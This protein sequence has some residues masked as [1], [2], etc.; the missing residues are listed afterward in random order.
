M[1][2]IVEIGGKQFRVAKDQNLKV[3]KINADNGSSI[4]FDRVLFFSDDAGKSQFGQPLVKDMAVSATVV[5][6]GREKKI[7]VFKKKRR[8]GYQVKNG[9]RQGYTLIKIQD[10]GLAKRAATAKVQEE[11]E[12]VVEKKVTKAEKTVKAKPVVDKAPAKAKVV[13]T[14]DSAEKKT[15]KPKTTKTVKAKKT[16][17]PSEGKEA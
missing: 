11:T 6:H 2:A 14:K 3:P 12:P 10:I 7:I 16:T 17:T 5:E 13:K 8:K 1:Y 4:S 9:H 15:A